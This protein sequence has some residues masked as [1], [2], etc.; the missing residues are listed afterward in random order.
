MN[1][2]RKRKKKRN[3]KTHLRPK[4]KLAET[5]KTCHFRRRKRK[6]ISVDLYYTALGELRTDSLADRY[7]LH[8]YGTATRRV[9]DTCEQ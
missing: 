9:V 8:S 7:I 1:L 3:Y 4:T 6:L 5:I 2:G